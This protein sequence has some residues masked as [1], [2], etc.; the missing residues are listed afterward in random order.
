MLCVAVSEASAAT[1]AGPA[2]SPNPL[3]I[4]RP[5]RPVPPRPAQR[6]LPKRDTCNAWLQPYSRGL[7]SSMLC[8]AVA[9]G[10]LLW[11]A[12]G[13]QGLWWAGLVPLPV[14]AVQW[15]L[16]RYMPETP[17][18]LENVGRPSEAVDVRRQLHGAQSESAPGT[19]RMERLMSPEPRTRRG[20]GEAEA[21]GARGA[22]AAKGRAARAPRDYVELVRLKRRLQAAAR[23]RQQQ[24]RRR[25]IAV[26]AGLFVLAPLAATD[27]LRFY[28][29]EYI[30][31]IG[32][33]EISMAAVIGIMEVT[34][35]LLS[36]GFVDCMGR[37]ALLF[38]STLGLAIIHS[39]LSVI[40][41]HERNSSP[42]LFIFLS[43]LFFAYD[44]GLGS[45][46]WVVLS[47]MLPANGRA[48]LSGIIVLLH[49]SVISGLI[50]LFPI[51]HSN[52]GD[53]WTFI[54]LVFISLANNV[55]VGH[56]LKETKKRTLEEI[57]K[58]LEKVESSSES[59]EDSEIEW[60]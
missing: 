49:S 47:D 57:E 9:L 23:R 3:P 24:S 20:E 14:L 11:T 15:L 31:K 10:R 4:P 44:I 55:Y 59:S 29:E 38:I 58:E 26:S 56:L 17:D 43:G 60:S 53:K 13:H 46:P 2:M 48:H 25:A 40:A 8:V 27:V 30:H 54:S 35:M 19:W 51:F 41:G 7:A 33:S 21:G 39:G 5:L 18:F 12:C 45:V 34:A 37:R 22:N 16:R 50:Y 1:R 6:G 42:W 32:E 36:A 52:V 28:V